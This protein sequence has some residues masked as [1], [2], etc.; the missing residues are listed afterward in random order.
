[1]GIGSE[2][3]AVLYGLASAASWGAGDFSGGFAT[4]RSSVYSVVI[5]SQCVGAIFLVGVALLF[6][7]SWPILSDWLYGA[8]AGLA[9]VVGL[10]ALYR[11]L[12]LGRMGLVAPLAAVVTAI[13]PVV[14]SIF[15]EGLPTGLQLVGFA[16][17]LLAVWLIA[18]NGAEGRIQVT[19][20]VFPVVAGLGFGFFFIL[21]DRVTEGNIFWPLVAARGASVGML[22]LG[23][24][25]TRQL[26]LP[27]LSQ[28][29]II[30]LAGLLDT[31][32]NAF[33]VLAAQLG[34]LD[35]AAVLS[36]LYPATT[37]ILAWLIL[38]ERLTSQ[39]WLGV[40]AALMAVMLIAL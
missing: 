40:W 19:D 32:G 37:V 1:L 25:L 36:S 15:S 4:K 5:V 20:L 16:V 3:L 21:I 27:R 2:L 23:L 39:Q 29:P 10:V 7:E 9:G 17:A 33:F 11:G 13:V 24:S 38:Q 18:G 30:A 31:G 28:F 12:A 8:G 22:L 6:G 34:R 35:I 14:V 26:E